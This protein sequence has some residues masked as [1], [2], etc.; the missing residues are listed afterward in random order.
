MKT[1]IIKHKYSFFFTVLT[2]IL[3]CF[4]LYL[5]YKYNNS[6][7]EYEPRTYEEFEPIINEI[8]G[9]QRGFVSLE[10]ICSEESIDG[11]VKYK[12]KIYP[13][14]RKI[15]ITSSWE[16][17]LYE[18]DG[19]FN[20]YILSNRKLDIE[21]DRAYEAN[22]IITAIEYPKIFYHN[23]PISFEDLLT[24]EET[25]IDGYINITIPKFEKKI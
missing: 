10:F 19:S 16:K 7:T 21:Q 12:Y 5:L 6:I 8:K 14:T 13:I 9:E 3:I 18:D 17:Y 4:E 24:N 23:V 22:Y 25:L 11:E 20:E 1:F 2:L 15:N